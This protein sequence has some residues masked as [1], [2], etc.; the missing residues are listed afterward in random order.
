MFCKSCGS[1][2]NENARF[3]TNCGTSVNAD[4]LGNNTDMSQNYAQNT[5]ASTYSYASG[6]NLPY[7]VIQVTL[8][9]KFIGTGSKNLTQLESVINEQVSRGYKLHTIS[10][11]ASTTSTGLLGGE[12]IQATMVFEKVDFF[13]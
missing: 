6:S 7:I 3:C 4:D 12:R 2:L 13:K 10:T 5:D 9:E 8:K 11:T 1:N